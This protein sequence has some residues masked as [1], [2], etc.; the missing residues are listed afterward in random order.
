MHILELEWCLT[1]VTTITSP[2]CFA[3][4][5][6]GLRIAEAAAADAVEAAVLAIA[7]FGAR[8]LAQFAHPAGG[9]VVEAVSCL[10]VAGQRSRALAD[11]LAAL[12]VPALIALV[13]ALCPVVPRLAE[14]LPSLP[15]KQHNEQ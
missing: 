13:L 14:T 15:Y 8:R 5:F 6:T 9:A 3:E 7:A 1:L 2:S 4:A 10:V 12:A 11:L